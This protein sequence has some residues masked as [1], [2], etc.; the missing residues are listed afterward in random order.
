MRVREIMSSSPVCCDAQ[1]SLLDVARLMVE[2]D[3]GEI[4]IVDAGDSG[5]P[6][7]VVIDRDI[8]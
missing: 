1:S 2:H 3:C 8:T 6:I 5:R 7:G 4:P